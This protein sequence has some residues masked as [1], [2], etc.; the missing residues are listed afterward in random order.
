MKTKLNILHSKRKKTFKGK[1]NK[2]GS[3]YGCVVNHV[4]SYIMSNPAIFR[5]G[6][7]VEI[8]VAFAVVPTR[9]QLYMASNNS[10]DTCYKLKLILRS[11]CL[12]DDSYTNIRCRLTVHDQ[13]GV[14]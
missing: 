6:D 11:I 4:Y 9:Q 13:L 1:Q 8:Q 14:Y 3:K 2:H 12:L 7:I 10:F 5:E